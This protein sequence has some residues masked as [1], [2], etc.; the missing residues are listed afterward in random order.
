MRRVVLNFKEKY[1]AMSE[2][3]IEMTEEEYKE[4]YNGRVPLDSII[5]YSNSREEFIKKAEEHDNPKF[6]IVH[7]TSDDKVI[8][9][10]NICDFE[11]ECINNG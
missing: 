3:I 11:L 6:K 10:L 7:V 5:K 8:N 4:Y 2:I 1:E 9:N